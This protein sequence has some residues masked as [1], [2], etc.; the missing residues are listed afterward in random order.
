M[1]P[2]SHTGSCQ[3]CPLAGFRIISAGKPETIRHRAFMATSCLSELAREIYLGSLREFHTVPFSSPAKKPYR[4]PSDD[5]CSYITFPTIDTAFFI[6]TVVISAMSEELHET[7]TRSPCRYQAT[8][9]QRLICF[10]CD[11]NYYALL[12]GTPTTQRPVQQAQ[13]CFSRT[14][15]Q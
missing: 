6:L 7:N 1:R 15:M 12:H 13:A 5:G 4:C 3:L 14:V 8:E 9:R 11:S 10:T 2:V